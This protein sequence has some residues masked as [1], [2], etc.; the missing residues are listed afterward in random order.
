MLQS[1]AMTAWLRDWRDKISVPVFVLA[2]SFNVLIIAFG[3]LWTETAGRVFGSVLSF[4]TKYF[5]WYY[6]AVVSALLVFVVWLGFSR[7]GSIRLGPPGSRPEFG[8]FSWFSMLFA[9]GMGMGLVFWGVAEPL[10]HY[11]DPPRATPETPEALVEAMRFAFFHWGF[12][13]W[14]IYIV[15]ALGIGYF[16]YRHGLPLAPR[17]L[18]YPLLG[19]RIH[20]WIGHLTDAFC[21]VGT[22]LGVATSLGLGAMQI[23]SGLETLFGVPFDVANQVVIIAVITVIAT[24]STVTGVSRGI[25]YLSQANI[26]LM[27]ALLTFV[28]LFGPTLFQVELFLTSLGDYLQN[29][30][31]TSLWVDV[32]EGVSWQTDWT[33]FYWGWWISWCPFVGIFVARVSRG[34]TIREVVGYVFLVPSL[35]NF[36]WFS[37]FGGTAMHL[38]LYEGIGIAERVQEDVAMSLNLLLGALPWA[39]ITQWLGILLAVIFFITSSDSGS[40][41]DDM[42]TCGGHPNP[43][44]ANRVFWGVSEGAAAASLLLAG[45]LTALQAAS[46]SAGLPQ[47]VLLIL[48]CVS[49]YRALRRE[50]AAAT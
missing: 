44:V 14:A 40:F 1:Q 48:A 7:F 50:P 26:L 35:A 42:V 33:R 17:S 15:F 43:P 22:L 47:S 2:A 38:E 45:G 6:I 37:V 13:P 20:G 31:E 41:V 27:L 4:I 21:V 18:L 8:Y 30:I 24:L 16:H 29:V 11:V 9:A 39:A 23:N 32:G 25:K 46:V 12:H 19:N 10:I 36:V 3:T 34:R 5:G 28:F 49:L